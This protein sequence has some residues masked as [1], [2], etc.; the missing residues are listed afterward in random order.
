ML[1]YHRKKQKSRKLFSRTS[2]FRPII[3]SAKNYLPVSRCVFI[4]GMRL[5]DILVNSTFST[6]ADPALTEP[7]ATFRCHRPRCRAIEFVGSTETVTATNGYGLLKKRHDYTVAEV[8]YVIA[9]Q[10]TLAKPVVG[11]QTFPVS[12]VQRRTS[13]RALATRTVDSP[14]ANTSTFHFT[15]RSRT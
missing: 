5:R 12:S 4:G 13:I 14:L 7:A 11:L 15:T 3:P 9:C 10:R 6:H 1:T 8:F 2:V